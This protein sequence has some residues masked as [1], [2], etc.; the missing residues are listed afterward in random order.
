MSFI[1]GPASP[2]VPMPTA[3]I[4]NSRYPTTEYPDLASASLVQAAD[5]FSCSI[6]PATAVDSSTKKLSGSMGNVTLISR[7][8]FVPSTISSARRMLSACTATLYRTAPLPTSAVILTTRRPPLYP[9]RA[10]YSRLQHFY[11]SI[12]VHCFLKLCN[13]TND[14]LQIPQQILRHEL[15][16][17]SVV[18]VCSS[19]WAGNDT[20][21]EQDGTV[22]RL[23]VLA[24]RPVRPEPTPWVDLSTLQTL[25]QP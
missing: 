21:I 14:I 18:R 11:Y 2:T 7:P 4:G 1:F 19:T 16:E 5:C 9:N 15:L 24:G 8:G 6:C 13:N 3:R 25:T 10:L 12:N 22:D 20:L 23:N 17:T